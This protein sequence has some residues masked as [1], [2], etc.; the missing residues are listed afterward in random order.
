MP[1]VPNQYLTGA[2]AYPNNLYYQQPVSYAQP[3]QQSYAQQPA[4]AMIWVDGE[5]GAKAYQMPA[6]QTGPVALWDTND[7][8]IYLKS[9]NQMGMPN[10]IQKIH[11]TMEENKTLM[12]GQ[13]GN[14]IPVEAKEVDMSQYVTKADFEKM[15]QELKNT[16]SSMSNQNGG[17]GNRGGR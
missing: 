6:G 17:N 1:Y 12:P 10:P 5:V 7:T 3:M 4:G 13:S 11:Y 8:V 14:T 2:M 9:M 16:I 15:K